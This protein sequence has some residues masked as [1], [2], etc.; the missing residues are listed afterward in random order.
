MCTRALE[1]ARFFV[2][3]R[4]IV[5]I[6][7][8]CWIYLIC[9]LQQRDRLTISPGPEIEFAKLMICVKTSG[10]GGKSGT[11]LAFRCV[12]LICVD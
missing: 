12:V 9:S 1:I 6:V 4:Q 5:V 3:Q 8:H 10:S 11:Q 7:I 2:R